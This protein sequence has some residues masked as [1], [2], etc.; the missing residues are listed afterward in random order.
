MSVA[1][2]APMALLGVALVAIPIAIHLLVRQQSRRVEFPS[3]RFL[4]PSQ[5]AAFRRRN[6]QDAWLL[7]CRAAIVAV[8]ALALAGPLLQT[9]SRSAGYGARTAR[10]V[11]VEPGIEPPSAITLAGDAFVSKSFARER[12]GD[13]IA[14]ATRWLDVQPPASRELVFVGAFRRG[15][16]AA[17]D[18]RGIGPT[19]GIR[20]VAAGFTLAGRDAQLPVLRSGSTGLFIEQQQV[21]LED[22]STRV[23][24]GVT[25]AAASDLVR[26][27]AAPLSQA[28][29]DAALRAALAEGLAWKTP[30]QRLLVAWNG[31]DE[32]LVQRLLL[33]ATLI[34]MPRPDP[35]ATSAS[36]VAAAIMAETAAPT[37]VMEPVAISQQQLQAWSRPPSGVPASAP[38]TDEGDR[39]WLWA[40]ALGLLGLEHVLRRSKSAEVA[41]ESVAGARVA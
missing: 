11:I 21:H 40:L 39:R 38:A 5:L 12:V 37:A 20:F 33:G 35:P 7:A 29:A 28:L 9:A 4:L 31:V 17:G 14:D 27:V 34:R 25:T 2:L 30:V 10:A 13:A 41:A 3:L 22:D 32:A 8:A 19:V 36:A 23:T 6:L 18:L 26:I 16:V 15:S 1:W 24:T